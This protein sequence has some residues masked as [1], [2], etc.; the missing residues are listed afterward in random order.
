M[1]NRTSNSIFTSKL[2]FLQCRSKKSSLGID[3]AKSNRAIFYI[4]GKR[5]RRFFIEGFG[6]IGI[7][8]ENP[9]LLT[10][11]VGGV[12]RIEEKMTQH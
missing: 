2:P 6:K 10:H 8:T 1:Q 9:D 3:K 4:W 7:I 12:S 11:N 5:T